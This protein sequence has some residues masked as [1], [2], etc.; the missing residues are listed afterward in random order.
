MVPRS[1]VFVLEVLP[2]MKEVQ[3]VCL[4]CVQ[5]HKAYSEGTRVHIEVWIVGVFSFLF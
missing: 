3:Q 2:G 5:G 4:P 1:E